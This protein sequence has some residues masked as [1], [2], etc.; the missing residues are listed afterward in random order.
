MFAFQFLILLWVVL[1]LSE[2]FTYVDAK[3]GSFLDYTK[4][5]SMEILYLLN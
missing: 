2:K 5:V 4:G 1:T 3:N